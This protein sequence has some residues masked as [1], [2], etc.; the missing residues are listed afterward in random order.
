LRLT[1][2]L[3]GCTAK[4]PGNRDIVKDVQDK[5]PR[6]GYFDRENDRSKRLDRIL[7]KT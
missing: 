5:K 6:K 3:S 4:I 7:G 2:R 1:Y